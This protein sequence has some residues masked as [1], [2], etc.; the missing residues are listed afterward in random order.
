MKKLIKIGIPIS[1]IFL[2][3]ACGN[4]ENKK[5]EVPPENK[6]SVVIPKESIVKI[7][8]DILNAIYSH[9]VHLTAALAKDNVAEAKLAAN[10]IEAGALEI[11]SSSNLAA[12]AAAIVSAPDIDKQRAAYS[13]LSNEL[14]SLLKKTG[15]ADAELY[16]EY[17]P[18]AFG[19]K[20]AVWISSTKEVRNP[21]FG[22]KMLKCGEVKEII[23]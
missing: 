18:M 8:D 21:Y 2:L 7:N 20:G 10:A 6:T 16:V 14:V 17:C 1:I 3:T 9:Y 12:D 15:M 5:K 4:S 13:D 11:R 23:K 19:N 22:E